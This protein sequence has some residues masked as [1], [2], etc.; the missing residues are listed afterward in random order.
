MTSAWA[1]TVH[2]RPTPQGSKRAMRTPGGR[3][4]MV[5]QSSKH[6]HPWR[7]ALKLVAREHAPH[8]PISGPVAL[9]VTFNLHRP[10]SHYGSG[11]NERKLKPSAP[12]LPTTRSR[13][14]LS[15][16]VRAVEDALT[17]AGWW[18]DDSQVV[19]FRHVCKR[20]VDRFT[21]REGAHIRVE[22][23]EGAEHE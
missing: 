14:D 10:Q 9:T 16:L 19:E 23:L 17:E 20:Y 21:Q 4:V 2:G 15:K 8:Q 1:V 18:L 7:D 5:E 22:L 3:P 13:G 6:L 11:R 12:H